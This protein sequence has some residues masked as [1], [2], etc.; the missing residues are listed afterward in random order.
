M[1]QS[2]QLSSSDHAVHREVY[3]LWDILRH[4]AVIHLHKGTRIKQAVVILFFGGGGGGGGIELLTYPSMCTKNV[5]TYMYVYSIIVL[6][7]WAL[8]FPTRRGVLLA[9]CGCVVV[10]ESHLQ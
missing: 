4:D 1:V 2:C 7:F 3:S 8:G 9:C 6:S 10:L 5:R